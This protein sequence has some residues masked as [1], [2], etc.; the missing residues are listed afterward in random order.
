MKI[1]NFLFYKSYQLA[2]RSKNFDSTPVLGGILWVMGCF[3][4]NTFTILFL[5][6]GSGLSGS[7]ILERKY[8]YIISFV[9]VFFLTF[10]Y[11]YRGRYKKIVERFKERE[12]M[13]GKEI[14]PLIVVILYLVISFVLM[15]LA[16]MYKNGDGIFN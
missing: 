8:K 13:A 14:Q 3:M 4:F 6:E 5:F 16:G 11:S 12:R 15:L 10:Y 7:L 2:E 9:L 1:Y